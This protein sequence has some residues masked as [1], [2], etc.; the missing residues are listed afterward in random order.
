VLLTE[1]DAMIA[2]MI[3]VIEEADEETRKN[4]KG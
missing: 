4:L 1:S 3:A 2:T